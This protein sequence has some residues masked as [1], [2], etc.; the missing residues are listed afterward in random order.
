M[1]KVI[2][3]GRITKD[4]EVRFSQ[5]GTSSYL[6]FTLAVDRGTKDASG[7]RTAD[8]INCTAWNQQAEFL[9]RFVRKGYLLSVV[10]RLQTRTYQAQDGQN[11]YVTE[12]ICESVENLQPR[13]P[14]QPQ[15]QP[16]QTYQAPQQ[17]FQGYQ[18]PTYSGQQNMSFNSEPKME[19]APK[20]FDID[21]DDNDLPF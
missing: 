12:V 15:Q 13:D 2:L 6:M 3:I 1:N 10:G 17:Q 5:N 7:Q 16:Q 20:S 8:F 21:L 9:S 11:R 18:N 19:E 4:P 14:N